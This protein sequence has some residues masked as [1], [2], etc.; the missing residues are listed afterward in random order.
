[1]RGVQA[2]MVGFQSRIRSRTDKPDILYFTTVQG[3]YFLVLE[4]FHAS[5]ALFLSIVGPLFLD[6]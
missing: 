4:C 5:N 1:M 6:L 3:D 2:T